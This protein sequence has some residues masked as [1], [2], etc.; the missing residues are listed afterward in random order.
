MIKK[1][2][3]TGRSTNSNA[4]DI[5][6]H[7]SQ[8]EFP[9]KIV[10]LSEITSPKRVI[11]Y[12]TNTISE[13][14]EP[15]LMWKEFYFGPGNTNPKSF[16]FWGEYTISGYVNSN[17]IYETTVVPGKKYRVNEAGNLFELMGNATSGS[18]IQILNNKSETLNLIVKKSNSLLSN[19]NLNPNAVKAYSFKPTAYIG[20]TTTLSG[21][22]DIS[23]VNTELGFLGVRSADINLLYGTSMPYQFTFSNVV[24][25]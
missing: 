5:K 3:S 19:I 7:N 4:L 21:Y 20:A 18:Q 9:F 10:D 8:R 16:N 24:Y 15:T 6:F 11:L 22:H 2:I 1:I 25:S 13:Y 23:E 12:I 14:G 17:Y